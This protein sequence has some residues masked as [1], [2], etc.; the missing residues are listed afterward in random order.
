M[1]SPDRIQID[2]H[3]ARA[4]ARSSTTAPAA[5]GTG[6]VL[7]VLLLVAGAAGLAWWWAMQTP[8]GVGGDAHPLPTS[9]AERQGA[10]VERFAAEDRSPRLGGE[11]SA[12]HQAR[13]AAIRAQDAA[14]V[15]T[16]A[17]VDQPAST[18]PDRAV[19]GLPAPAPDLPAT[20]VG[21][22]PQAAAPPTI[23]PPDH[24]ALN[25]AHRVNDL[26]GQR[27]AHLRWLDACQK[28]HLITFARAQMA[29]ARD[30]AAYDSA[31]IAANNLEGDIEMH[32]REARRIDHLLTTAEQRLTDYCA[33]HGQALPPLENPPETATG[34]A[35][36]PRPM[37]T[38]TGPA[39]TIRPVA[40]T[41]PATRANLDPFASS[42]GR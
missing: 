35:A 29:S 32:Q 28:Q 31:R 5:Y 6:S 13:L 16:P 10:V 37:P 11:T 14:A 12:Q 42:T 19:A 34:V 25:L 2:D 1:A 20:S 30:S 24:G 26:R 15:A 39:L 41:S 38:T 36:Q 4:K 21:R 3:F 18:T 7:A 17:A 33:V 27:A 8:A 23:S 22:Q 40:G 9:V